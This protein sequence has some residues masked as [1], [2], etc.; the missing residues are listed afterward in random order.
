MAD[1]FVPQS[2]LG[3]LGATSAQA[4][5][6]QFTP[7]ANPWQGYAEQPQAPA[8]TAPYS[9][10]SHLVNG[11]QLIPGAPGYNAAAA[12]PY[13]QQAPTMPVA[14]N[15]GGLGGLGG[16]SPQGQQNP[17]AQLQSQLASWQQSLGANFGPTYN[18]AGVGGS[19][20]KVN[21]P[22]YRPGGADGNPQAK[23][24]FSTA[25]GDG[26]FKLTR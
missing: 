5:A 21:S 9:G 13:Q 22:V 7:A 12:A 19:F 14:S 10:G 25:W 17:L 18:P 26:P 3:A 6:G 4:Q 20:S 1:F 2:L 15:V 8:A 11:V 23:N 24:G 16:M